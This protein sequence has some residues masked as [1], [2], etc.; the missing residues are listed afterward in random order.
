MPR[1]P[2]KKSDLLEIP[3]IG[4]TFVTDFARIGV[5]SQTDLVDADPDELFLRLK[6][7]NNSLGHATSK[8]YLYVLR[9]AI[10]YASGGRDHGKL[11]WHVWKD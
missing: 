9:M 1:Q 7:E 8:N 5:K 10:Y 11:K 4:Q 2:K 3:G 6:T